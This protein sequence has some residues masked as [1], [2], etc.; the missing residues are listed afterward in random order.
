[1]LSKTEIEEIKKIIFR[2][3]DPDKNSVFIFGSRAGGK[4]R[5]FSDVDIGIKGNKKIPITLIS[6]IKDAFEESDIPYMV[7]IIDFKHVTKNFKS[8]ALQQTLSLN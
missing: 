6:E 8:I 4:N 1:M 5:K 3:I 7:D 2:F